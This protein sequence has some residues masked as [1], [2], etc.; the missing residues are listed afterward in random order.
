MKR[1]LCIMT[2]DCQIV[3]KLARRAAIETQ[4]PNARGSLPDLMRDCSK[5]LMNKVDYTVR[6]VSWDTDSDNAVATFRDGYTHPNAR[7]NTREGITRTLK[8]T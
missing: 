6:L 2:L 5:P 8:L 7:R 4:I 3:R 1:A